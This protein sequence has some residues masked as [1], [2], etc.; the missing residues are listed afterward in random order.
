MTDLNGETAEVDV[1][2]LHRV[3]GAIQNGLYGHGGIDPG[4]A[5]CY[6]AAE[7]VIADLGLRR[8]GC[9]W[10]FN[11]DAVWRHTPMEQDWNDLARHRPLEH[12]VVM[13]YSGGS[14]Q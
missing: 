10:R 6:S 8:M 3:A 4:T 1:D 7:R 11:G 12:V 14:A 5:A 13:A 9:L 2:L